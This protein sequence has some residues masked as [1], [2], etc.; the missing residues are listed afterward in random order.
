MKMANW[1]LMIMDIKVL[2]AVHN[3]DY[4]AKAWISEI[5]YFV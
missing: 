4:R 1:R 5:R 2:M 3:R